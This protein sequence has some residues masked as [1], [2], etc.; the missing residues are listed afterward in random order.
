MNLNLKNK[1]AIVTGGASGIGAT[2]ALAFAK[3]GA[4]VVIADLLDSRGE[5]IVRQIEAENGKAI[6]I[7]CDVSI[8]G[9]IEN[10][11][12][13]TIEK[14]GHLNCAFNN[15]GIDGGRIAR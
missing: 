5:E 9:D 3:E 13:K 10:M 14:F 1:V 8:E 11:V 6:F 12:T 2:T 15:A 7:K 4:S